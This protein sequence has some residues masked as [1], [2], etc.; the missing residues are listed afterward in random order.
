MLAMLILGATLKRLGWHMTMIIGILGHV[1]TGI[2][3]I[4]VRADASNSWVDPRL[5]PS[6]GARIVKTFRQ[7][8]H[9]P[10]GQCADDPRLQLPDVEPKNLFDFKVAG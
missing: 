9:C 10:P 4:N 5:R 7:S 6:H 1:A 2:S 8:R 3:R